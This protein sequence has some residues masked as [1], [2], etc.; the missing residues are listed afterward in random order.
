MNKAEREVVLLLDR[1]N[2]PVYQ[3]MLLIEVIC[4]KIKD[5][6]KET[7]ELI[8]EA[9]N[10]TMPDKY[11]ERKG[12]KSHVRVS[13]E[14]ERRQLEEELHECVNLPEEL[15]SGD[16]VEETIKYYYKVVS[17]ME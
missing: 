12:K 11:K 10:G 6:N 15:F 8:D 1:L 13:V 7:D 16:I 17:G 5:P 14:R 9:I 3:R 4:R 2:M